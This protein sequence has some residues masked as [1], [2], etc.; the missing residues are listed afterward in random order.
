MKNK[1]LAP[2]NKMRIIR[3]LL[4]LLVLAQ[5]IYAKEWFFIALGSFFMLLPLLN[6]GCGSTCRT[7]ESKE[8]QEIEDITYEEVR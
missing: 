8:K 5:G 4:A 2:W 3:L 7:V 1:L 6:V